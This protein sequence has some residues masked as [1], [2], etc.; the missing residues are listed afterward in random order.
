MAWSEY[1]Q[2]SLS[3]KKVGPFLLFNI[4]T[5]SRVLKSLFFL[6]LAKLDC[7]KQ[8]GINH[9]WYFAKTKQHHNNKKKTH[10]NSKHFNVCLIIHLFKSFALRGDFG[11]FTSGE[12]YPSF[13]KCDLQI[14]QNS[15]R[16]VVNFFS[17]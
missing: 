6:K 2:R 1:C 16:F 10:I 7:L 15:R 14:N 11:K 8:S 4:L 9:F 17:K 13:L 3:L 5:D 12:K